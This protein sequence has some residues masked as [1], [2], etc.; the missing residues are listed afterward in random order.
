MKNTFFAAFATVV[1]FAAPSFAADTTVA[2]EVTTAVVAETAVPAP[3]I[4]AAAAPVWQPASRPTILPALYAGS[5]LLQAYDAYSTMKALNLGGVEANP[6]AKGVV[7][8]PALFIGVK[9]AVA[10]ASI[11]AAEKMWKNHHRLAAIATMAATNSIM[12]MVAAH[13]AGVIN[14]LQQR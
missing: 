3:A 11:L 9:A 14:Q 6:V 10:A 1:L 7:G 13:N 2:G 5:A 8:N 12:A 4:V